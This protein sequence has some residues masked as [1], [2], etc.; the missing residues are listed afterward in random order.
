[1]IWLCLMLGLATPAPE[2]HRVVAL[3]TDTDPAFAIGRGLRCP[4]CQGMPIS[5][6]P[7]DMA[8][9]MMKR[10]REMVAEGQSESDIK[11]YFVSRYGEWVLLEPTHQGVNV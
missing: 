10:V 11:A 3:E 9:A 5:E 8:Q 4:V 1:M 2:S 7:S 6:S